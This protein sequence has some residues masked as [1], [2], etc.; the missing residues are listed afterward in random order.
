[1]RFLFLLKEPELESLTL[2]ERAKKSLHSKPVL[3]QQQQDFSVEWQTR[4]IGLEEQ[5]LQIIEKELGL[6]EV[7]G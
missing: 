6:A 2:R 1:M 4:L 3:V 7:I 5:E